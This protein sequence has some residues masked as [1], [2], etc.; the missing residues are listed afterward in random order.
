MPDILQQFPIK[1]TRQKVFEAISTPAGLDRW[2]TK[3]SAGVPE[4]GT[5]FELWFG[6]EYDW[7]AVVSRCVPGIEFELQLINASEDWKGTRVGFLLHSQEDVTQV[8]FHHLGWP[9]ANEHYCVSCHCW[10]LY[11]RL[12]RC[13]LEH[14]ELVPYEERLDA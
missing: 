7:R 11:L 1:A 8:R 10:A 3:H 9:D 14:G 4:V 12:L 5:E 6:T 13:N 2:W